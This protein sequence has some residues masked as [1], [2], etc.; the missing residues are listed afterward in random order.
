METCRVNG[1][2][3]AAVVV[4]VQGTVIAAPMPTRRT[5]AEVRAEQ[6]RAVTVVLAGTAVTART[7]HIA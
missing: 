3:V 1:L 2:G 7:L 6:H 4:L 5:L